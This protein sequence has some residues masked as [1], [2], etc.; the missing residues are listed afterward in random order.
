MTARITLFAVANVF[1]MLMT[2]D[3]AATTP[4]TIDRPRSFVE[5]TAW[6]LFWL[7]VS[8]RFRDIDGFFRLDEDAPE[9]SLAVVV[10]D[11]RSV[12]TENP[13]ADEFIRSEPMLDTERHPTALL[14][15]SLFK[16]IGKAKM[17]VQGH[18]KMKGVRLPVEIPFTFQV[19]PRGPDG[20]RRLKTG[21][22][23]KIQRLQYNIGGGAWSNT[24]LFHDQIEIKVQMEM[25]CR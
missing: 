9:K 1:V 18:L 20:I 24:F 13:E 22:T 16:P 7:P 8:G 3:A 14:K 21:G 19:S 10:I 5:F 15:T 11:A 17:L 25:K 4:C 23:F 6:Q 12:D 2:S